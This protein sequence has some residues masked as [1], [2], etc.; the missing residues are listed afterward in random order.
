MRCH[1]LL[2]PPLLLLPPSLLLLLLLLLL[3]PFT[4]DACAVCL[5]AQV[6]ASGG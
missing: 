1:L 5:P 3:L 6:P 2:V 4:C